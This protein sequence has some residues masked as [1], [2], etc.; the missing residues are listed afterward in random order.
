MELKWVQ[1]EFQTSDHENKACHVSLSLS[2]SPHQSYTLAKSKWAKYLPRLTMISEGSLDLS[3]KTF[4]A[5][6]I[7]NSTI[8]CCG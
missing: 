4:N 7:V 8:C 5:N 3:I 2:W 1:K 6:I